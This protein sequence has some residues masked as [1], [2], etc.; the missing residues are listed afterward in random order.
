[1][2][3]VPALGGPERK[4]TETPNY[5]RHTVRPLDPPRLLAW[6]HDGK[7]LV[8]AESNVAGG[9][10]GLVA[11]SFVSGER[12]RLTV[13]HSYYGDVNPAFSPDGRM[14]AF[15]RR[16][17]IDVSDLYVLTLAADLRPAGEPKR[18]TFDN[19][20]TEQPAWSS[21]GRTLIF[22][23]NRGGI[24][25]LWRVPVTQAARLN[26]SPSPAMGCRF[27]LCQNTGNGLRTAVRSLT[28]TFG[29]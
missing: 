3:V 16:E 28:A 2:M 15:N 14:L 23:S 6:S 22:A 29:N 21:D 18:I 19:R 5:D 4:L 13:T 20:R 17:T 25:G 26:P 12:R 8:I 11:Y 24:S 1:M 10:T 9:G 27:L 7:W